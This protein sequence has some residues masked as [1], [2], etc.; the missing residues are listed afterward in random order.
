MSE[1]RLVGL[2]GG[3]FNPVHFGHLRI[4]EE[5]AEG[6]GLSELIFMPAKNHP[7]KDLS[8]L[9]PL[10][11]RC[12]MLSMAIDGR[13]GFSVSDLE[14]RL[15]GPSYTVHTMR[16]LWKERLGRGSTL[17]FMVGFDSFK[18][19]RLWHDHVQLFRLAAFVVFAR[20]GDKGGRE[21]VGEVL[22]SVSP[23]WSW[24]GDSQSYV[25]GEFQPVKYFRQETMLRISSTA[26]RRRLEE[27]RSVRYLVPDSVRNY[28]AKKGL[29]L[30]S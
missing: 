22:D 13:D 5:I 16:A 6:L 21:A 14:G 12:E 18:Q 24:D 27:G 15:S 25:H 30:R 8:G 29:Y 17:V 28:I 11:A 2:F 23:G 20:P 26:L 10:L 3:T 9:A 7:H 1:S 4:A 19:V